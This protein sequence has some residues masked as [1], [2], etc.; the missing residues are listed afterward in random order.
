M[1]YLNNNKIDSTLKNI[2][3]QISQ[4]FADLVYD[5]QIVNICAHLRDL[6]EI[7]KQVYQERVQNLNS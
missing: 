1:Y 6:R 3:P 7:E 2:L 4:I 5:N